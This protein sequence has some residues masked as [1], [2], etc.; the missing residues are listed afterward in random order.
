MKEDELVEGG[1]MDGDGGGEGGWWVLEVV[2]WLFEVF[3]G[4]RPVKEDSAELSKQPRDS[5][6]SEWP[7]CAAG[8]SGISVIYVS[9]G[10]ASC[11]L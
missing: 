1:V 9:R 8:L 3:R 6:V 10:L 5:S 2:G 11:L 4:R 7:L